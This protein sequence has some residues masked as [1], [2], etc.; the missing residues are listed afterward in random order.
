MRVSCAATTDARCKCLSIVTIWET[1]ATESLGN[2]VRR[3]E[4]STFPGC[5]HLK[6]VVKGT[7]QRW[8]CGPIK[9]V[10]LN[11]NHRS[12][13]PGTGAGRRRQPPPNFA[14]RNYHRF[15]REPAGGEETNASSSSPTWGGPIRPR[16]LSGADEPSIPSASLTGGC[17]TGESAAQDAPPSKTSSEWIPFFAPKV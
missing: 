1:L 15:A 2:P 11:N 5:A 7:Q 17:V 12:S 4:N 13:E 6:F 3:A 10:T 9:S 8:R 14:L 16:G